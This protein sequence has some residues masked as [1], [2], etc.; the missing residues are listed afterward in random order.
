MK[1]N[2]IDFSSLVFWGAGSRGISLCHLLRAQPLYFVDSDA[3]KFNKYIP[4]TSIMI[5]SPATLYNDP[6]CPGVVITSFFY[7][8]EVISEL[9]RQGYSGKI[10][11]V[12]ENNDIVLCVG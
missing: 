9:L 8:K 3:S 1:S 7:F 5:Y 6:G 11:R 12:D 4:S 10:Y 2:S